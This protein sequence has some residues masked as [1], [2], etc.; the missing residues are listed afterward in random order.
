[1]RESPSTMARSA[2]ISVDNSHPEQS[3]DVVGFNNADERDPNGASTISP[4]DSYS[5]KYSICECT[6]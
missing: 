3:A 5:P 6:Q 1:M 4:V 2:A